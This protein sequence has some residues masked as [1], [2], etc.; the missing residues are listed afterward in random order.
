MKNQNSASK[1]EFAHSPFLDAL[2]DLPLSHPQN[3]LLC[4]DTPNTCPFH[5]ILMR[6]LMGHHL[7]CTTS[8]SIYLLIAISVSVLPIKLKFLICLFFIFRSLG[9][10][11]LY[12]KMCHLPIREFM[13]VIIGIMIRRS[14]SS[15]VY[16]WMNAV[17]YV[18]VNI[19]SVISWFSVRG[20]SNWSPFY[21]VPSSIKCYMENWRGCI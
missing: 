12:S 11:K 7:K 2:H 19:L 8:L 14:K 18:K 10:W 1:Y 20:N 21:F 13:N 15:E 4:H 16:P 17:L 3:L 9:Q 6:Y 5:G